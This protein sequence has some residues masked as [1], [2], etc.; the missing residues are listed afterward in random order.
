MLFYEDFHS[1]PKTLIERLTH[2]RANP[3]R[4]EAPSGPFVNK[5]A[6]LDALVRELH[7]NAKPIQAPSDIERLK[8]IEQRVI[9]EERERVPPKSGQRWYYHGKPGTGKTFRL[10][11][12]GFWHAMEGCNVLYLCFNKVLGADVQRTLNFSERLAL[13]D[14]CLDAR[15][16]FDV[17][18]RFVSSPVG[19]ED[20]DDWARTVVE[21]MREQV[22]ELKKYDTILID[23]AQDLPSWAFEMAFL[24]A[25]KN[26]T[27]LVAS[28]RGQEMYGEESEALTV[29]RKK[30]KN[31][32]C[33]RN[34]RNTEQISRFAMTFGDSEGDPSRIP[35]V[36][37]SLRLEPGSQQELI[38]ERPGGALPA[39]IFMDDSEIDALSEEAL[40]YA[41]LLD[42]ARI[43]QY[44]RIIEIE[45]DSLRASER[46]ID[47][48]ILVPSD[49]SFERNWVCGALDSMKAPYLD[50]TDPSKRRCPPQSDLIRV[51]TF[52]SSRGIEGQRVL[53]FGMERLDDLSKKIGVSPTKLGYIILSRASLDLAIAYR[54][55]L[56]STQMRFV[57][58]AIDYLR[59]KA[60]APSRS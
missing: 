4:G 35:A 19:D 23:E 53:I 52:H 16:A 44:Q 11:R 55:R 43:R 48:L 21:L 8:A 59:P 33:N 50:Y 38:F 41:D 9:K 13:S 5:R 10:L 47:M 54:P 25:A 6:D 49:K 17:L 36:V 29:F 30:A 24:H 60:G 14:G 22:E 2:I 39:L 32:R 28:G 58:A 42:N 57:E 34:F 56:K 46:P 45:R 37:K 18:R 51:C 12:I 31:H 1:T 3:P 26:A 20:H 27:I 7:V 40:D 15:D